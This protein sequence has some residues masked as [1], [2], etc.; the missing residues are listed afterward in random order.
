MNNQP[1]E[2]ELERIIAE[3]DKL[4]RNREKK[5]EEP[6]LEK[7][8]AELG[9]P[10]ELVEE[11]QRRIQWR[12]QV[13][14]QRRHQRRS[15]LLIGMG[16]SLV[17]AIVGAIGWQRVQGVQRVVA[18]QDVL[19][20][21]A[22]ALAPES[23][24]IDLASNPELRYEVVLDP[25]PQ[26]RKLSL[27]CDWIAPN[28]QILHQNRYETKVINKPVWPTSCRYSPGTRAMTGVWTVE[29]HLGDRVLESAQFEVK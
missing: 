19:Q 12:D 26:G 29:M 24:P 6:Q 18:V 9:L 13:A 4:D 11:A 22:V 8:I 16:L 28:G 10:P 1:T 17:V 25:A 27:G 14:A 15:L 2:E 3:V 21:G 5:L 7:V 23:G 20:V